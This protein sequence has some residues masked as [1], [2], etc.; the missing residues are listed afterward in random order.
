M[1]LNEIKLE[2]LE[3]YEDCG[4]KCREVLMY[5]DEFKKENNRDLDPDKD[6]V[7]IG[8]Y[9]EV[10]YDENGNWTKFTLVGEDIGDGGFYFFLKDNLIYMDK[11][12]ILL[13]EEYHELVKVTISQFFK[14]I[15]NTIDF[16]GLK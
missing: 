13:D 9:G 15:S 14:D 16:R 1:E 2:D 5:Q 10:V 6:M 12:N 11:D 4:M 7:L 3:N 8:E